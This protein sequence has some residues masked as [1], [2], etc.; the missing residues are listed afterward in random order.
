M[1]FQAVF[2][3]CLQRNPGKLQAQGHTSEAKQVS[4]FRRDWDLP[5]IRIWISLIV[6]IIKERLGNCSGLVNI[7][8]V[9]AYRS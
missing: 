1:A 5:V 9:N 2:L 6:K 8:T 7:W 3:F 4:E